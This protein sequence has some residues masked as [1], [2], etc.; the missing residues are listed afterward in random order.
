M[1]VIEQRSTDQSALAQPARVSLKLVPTVCCLC[2]VDDA[3]PVG[4]GADFEYRT[5]T[6]T[7]LAVRCGR[8]GLV[9]LNP[10]P[11]DEEMGRIYPDNYHAFAFD[12]SD[13]GFIYHVRRRLEARR[14]MTWCQGIPD[15]AKI[16]DVGC[17]DGFHLRL[18]RDFGKKGWTLQGLDSDARA[19]A[20]GQRDGLY[21]QQGR[22]EDLDL[23]ANSFHLILLI[24]TVEHLTDPVKVLKAVHRLLAPGGR[25]GIITDNV[26]SPDFTLFGGRHWGGY[27]FPGI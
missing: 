13:F 23:P 1:T 27:H 16:L 12:A 3:E 7:F 11:A 14:L 2:E 21:I 5:S 10:R 18:L 22:V 6:D 9:Y 25:V 26:G 15:N 20:A 19:V 24:M 8:C 17:G 4:V